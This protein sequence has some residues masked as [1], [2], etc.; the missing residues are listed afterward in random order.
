MWG[1]K[2][3]VHCNEYL[4]RDGGQEGEDSRILPVSDT[5]GL[6]VGTSRVGTWCGWGQGCRERPCRGGVGACQELRGQRVEAQGQCP[7]RQREAHCVR[8]R[9]PHPR[10]LPQAPWAAVTAVGSDLSLRTLAE[11]P[12]GGAPLSGG[13][14]LGAAA[15]RTPGHAGEDD[16]GPA[17]GQ[18]CR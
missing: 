11:L 18:E 3:S 12:C 10:S 15:Q 13:S 5:R 14:S 8:P 16:A 2:H 1:H 9:G 7:A 4:L 6:R 17:R